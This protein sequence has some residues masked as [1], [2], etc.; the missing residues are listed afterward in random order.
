QLFYADSG[1]VPGSDDYTTVCLYHGTMFYGPIFYKLF[2]YCASHNI[3]LVVV[4]RK[5]YPGSSKYTDDEIEDLHACRQVF[6][7]R[8]GT[9]VADFL[10]WFIS[11]HDI[12]RIGLHQKSGGIAVVGWSMGAA[13]ILPLLAYPELVPA[14]IRAKLSPYIK[15]YILYDPPYLALGYS[16]PA[17]HNAYNPLWTDPDCESP[18][19]RYTNFKLWISSYFKHPDVVRSIHDLDF[20]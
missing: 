20:R 4:N 8:L 19:E 13:T 17:D 3:R 6:L 16:L 9:E 14:G 2:P 12:P 11:A 15:D 18:E 10:V 7:Q 5:E 1:P